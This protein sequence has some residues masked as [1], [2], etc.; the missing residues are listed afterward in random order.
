MAQEVE[1]WKDVVGHEGKYQVSNLGR[2]RSVDRAINVICRNKPMSMRYKGRV[3]THNYNNHGYHCMRLSKKEYVLIHRMV[4]IA[5][6]PNPENKPFINHINGIKDDNRVENLEW[7]TC[8]ENS[9]HAI[10]TGLF[11]VNMDNMNLALA[12]FKNKFGKGKECRMHNAKLVLNT[13]TGIYYDS[14]G[15][16]AETI[17]RNP[18]YLSRELNG[19][20]KNYTPFIYV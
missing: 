1:I 15:D 4:A 6:I 9:Q 18:K 11:K 3:L 12:A 20:R 17:N 7:C 16:A 2:A 8:L 5:F 19:K 13:A 14:L 10:R